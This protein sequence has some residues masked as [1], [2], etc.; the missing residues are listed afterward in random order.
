MQRPAF[1][2]FLLHSSGC[3]LLKKQIGK[4]LLKHFE[5][6]QNVYKPILRSGE[7][8]NS[9][10]ASE[11]MNLY[12]RGEFDSAIRLY[13]SELQEHQD[14]EDL[15]FYMGIAYLGVSNTNKAIEL[16]SDIDESSK[17]NK[18]ADWYLALSYLLADQNER[19]KKLLQNLDYNQ[20]QVNDILQE[21]DNN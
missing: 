10:G 13:E 3:I 6:Y 12:E 7:S 19:A 21:I 9:G 5:P 18:M 14:N 4:Y 15:Q 11:I 16:L 17:Y 20:D 2:S 8:Q 1:F